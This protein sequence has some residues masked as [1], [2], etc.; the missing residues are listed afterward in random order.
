MKV[1]DVSALPK[2]ACGERKNKVVLNWRSGYYD[3]PL[4]GSCLLSEENC[5]EFWFAK[6]DEQENIVERVDDENEILRTRLFHL[7]QLSEEQWG[8]VNKWHQLFLEHVAGKKQEQ[9]YLFYDA[10]EKEEAKFVLQPSQVVGW[11]S[12]H[13]L[14][15]CRDFLV[16]GSLI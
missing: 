9:W 7:V 15:C 3:G 12:E 6:F 5:G 4:S 13:D 14:I 16:C 10:F 11:F 2:K 1:L 8:L